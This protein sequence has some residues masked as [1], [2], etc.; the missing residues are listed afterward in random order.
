MSV[1][2]LNF[3]ILLNF[4]LIQS[5]LIPNGVILVICVVIICPHLFQTVTCHVM[6]RGKMYNQYYIRECY[7]V[8]Q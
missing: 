1:G 6:V 3:F 4:E 7:L 5:S 8:L 2:F